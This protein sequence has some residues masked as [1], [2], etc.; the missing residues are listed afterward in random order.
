MDETKPNDDI[1]KIQYEELIVNKKKIEY[2][3]KVL[4]LKNFVNSYE[5]LEKPHLIYAASKFGKTTFISSLLYGFLINQPSDKKIWILNFSMTLD[6]LS[7]LKKIRKMI[8]EQKNFD[9]KILHTDNSDQLEKLTKHFEKIKNE[10][11]YVFI[12]MDDVTSFLQD[13]K[14][15]SSIITHLITCGRHAHMTLIISTHSYL[16][17]SDS[18]KS[19]LGSITF[20]GVKQSFSNLSA[21]WSKTPLISNIFPTVKDFFHAFIDLRKKVKKHTAIIIKEDSDIMQI[22]LVNKNFVEIL[23]S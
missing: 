2:Q 6:S 9:F 11:D 16:F 12:L 1:Q 23:N 14:K 7:K 4:D 15:S 3:W 18:I 21:I 19:N 8:N 13:K 5:F 10:Y 22:Y 20:L 17:L